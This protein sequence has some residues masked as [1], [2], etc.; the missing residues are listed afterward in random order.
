MIIYCQGKKKVS[1]WIN[2][3]PGHLGTRNNVS[4]SYSYCMFFI[5]IEIGLKGKEEKKK[6]RQRAGEIMEK[7][8]LQSAP[9]A[10]P[11]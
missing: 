1:D 9:A 5:L 6:K 8:S 4:F 11:C 10:G 3:N 2:P 7:D